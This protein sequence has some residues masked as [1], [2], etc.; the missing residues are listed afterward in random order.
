MR[1]VTEHVFRVPL[2]MVNVFLIVLPEGITMVDAGLR[3][4]FPR[5][6]K[7]IRGLGRRP[8]EVTDIVVTHL[9]AD[10]TGGLAEAR[11]ATGARVWMHPA[12]A[13]MVAAGECRRPTTPSPGS[14]AGMVFGLF[15]GITT[16]KVPPV[17]ADGLAQDRAEIPVAG[18]LLPV[19]TPGHSAGHV[20]YL[21][22]GDGGVLFVGDAAVRGRVVRVS[23]IYEDYQQGLR[24][25]REL[26]SFDFQVACFSHG[27]PLTRGAAGVFRQTWGEAEAGGAA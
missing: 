20:A 5:I 22:P 15:S 10:H 19:W 27:R 6:E 11:A 21:W 9:H 2:V 23:P 18:G 13:R 17:P 26:A 14:V 3:R 24:S 1:E 25:L 8:E 16:A 12:D 4:S 7:A